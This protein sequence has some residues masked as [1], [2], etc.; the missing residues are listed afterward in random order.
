MTDN[1]DIRVQADRHFSRLRDERTANTAKKLTD[2][3]VKA[4]SDKTARLKAARLAKAAADQK[5]TD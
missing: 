1:P 3:R 5:T 2:E 4:D